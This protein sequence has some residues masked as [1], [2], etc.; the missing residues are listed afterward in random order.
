MTAS[1]LYAGPVT[2]V[3]LRPRAHRLRYRIFQTLLDL[4]E[5]DGLSRRL[6]LFSRGR[7]NLFGFH[8][9]DHGDGTGDLRSY[10]QGVLA[11]AGIAFDGGAIRILCMPRVL[12][13]VF[14]PISLYFCHQRSGA[15]AAILYEVNN[16]FGQRHSYLF[17]VNDDEPVLRHGCDKQFYVSPFMEMGMRYDFEVTPPGDATSTVIRGSDDDGALIVAAFNG[18]RRELTDGVLLRA[19]LGHPLLTVKVVA[20][21][22]WEALKILAKGVRLTRRPPAPDRAVTV[23]PA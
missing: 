5:L 17:P 13:Y 20:G 7:F 15:L 4:D 9:K 16:T 2:H 18:S 23:S 11:E 1:G 3:R 21:I 12:G 8:D 22:H 19:F 14:N 10:V 6:K